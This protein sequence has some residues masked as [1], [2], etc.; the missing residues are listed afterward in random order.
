MG[1]EPLTANRRPYNSASPG[2]SGMLYD[3]WGS[4]TRACCTK[5]EAAIAEGATLGPAVRR[6]GQKRLRRDGFGSNG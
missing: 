3:G 2:A 1:R 5:A 6:L 4:D